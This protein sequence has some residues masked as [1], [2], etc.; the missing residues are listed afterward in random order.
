MQEYHAETKHCHLFNRIR[1]E[2][3]T[4]SVTTKFKQIQKQIRPIHSSF[5]SGDETWKLIGDDSFR[6]KAIRHDVEQSYQLAIQTPGI[7]ELERSFLEH[8]THAEPRRLNEVIWEVIRRGFKMQDLD[9]IYIHTA[10]SP[11]NGCNRILEYFV[12]I[13]RV[14]I[15]VTYDTGF[16]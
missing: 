16:F 10:F 6:Q 15:F 5:S 4:K 3:S 14:H 2:Q 12:K 8:R 7:K 1:R 13:F 9:F 11:C